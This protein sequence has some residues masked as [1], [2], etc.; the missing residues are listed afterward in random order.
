VE[1]KI[2]FFVTVKNIFIIFSADTVGSQV[3]GKGMSSN[4][5]RFIIGFNLGPNQI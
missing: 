3:V 5:D 2:V 1:K 4:Q